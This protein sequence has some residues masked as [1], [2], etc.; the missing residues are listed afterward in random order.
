MLLLL[1]CRA[2]YFNST[3]LGWKGELEVEVEALG[4]V[5]LTI[6]YSNGLADRT[7]RFNLIYDVNSELWRG[8][9]EGEGKEEGGR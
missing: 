2:F 6:G 5:T 8:V 3:V 9:R 4:N 1:V 7:K